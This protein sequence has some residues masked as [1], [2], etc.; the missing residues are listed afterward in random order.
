MISGILFLN[1]KGEVLISRFYRENVSRTST[2]A[3]RTQIIGAKKAGNPVI[4]IDKQSFLYTRYNDVYVVSITKSNANAALIFSF[5]YKMIELFR[6][7]FGG[8]FDEESV[9]ANFVLIY[10]LL[11]ECCDYGFP[12]ITAINILTSYIKHG[13]VKKSEEE[14][15]SGSSA[16]DSGITSEITGNVDWRQAGKY[17][18][19]KNEIF[20][21]ALEA[22]N[23][24][25]S[26]QGQVL[27]A[28]VSGKIIMKTYLTGMPEARLGINDRLMM[29]KENIANPKRKGNSTGIVIEDISFHRC[30]KLGKWTNS[31]H[32]LKINTVH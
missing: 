22:V 7:Y 16:G 21:D 29:E 4:N 23:L 17:K 14:L 20:I 11:D 26:S 15:G 9:K 25:M 28:D 19:R 24:L 1:Q 2:D 8:N 6:S 18:Y 31:Q 3:F 12:Q 30:V 27:R 13:E 10:E 32:G 5:M